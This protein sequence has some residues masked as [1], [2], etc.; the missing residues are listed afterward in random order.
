MGIDWMPMKWLSQAIPPAYARFIGEQAI[1][2]MTVR[3]GGKV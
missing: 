2:H 1:A 3:T